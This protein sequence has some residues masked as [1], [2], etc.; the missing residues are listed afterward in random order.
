M[1]MYKRGAARRIIGSRGRVQS[2][3]GRS[4]L[5]KNPEPKDLAPPA[6]NRQ[7]PWRYGQKVKTRTTDG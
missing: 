4:M 1:W 2:D 3:Q 5:V 7:Q 6:S